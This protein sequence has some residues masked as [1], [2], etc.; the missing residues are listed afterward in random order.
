MPVSPTTRLTKPA[1]VEWMVTE[2]VRGS[3]LAGRKGDSKGA[4]G[5]ACDL[6]SRS[7]WR[8][9]CNRLRRRTGDRAAR[10]RLRW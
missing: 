4:G 6:G 7:C 2:P 3:G 5:P 8:E 9:D 10:L 1:A